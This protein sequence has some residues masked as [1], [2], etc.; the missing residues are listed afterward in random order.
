MVRILLECFNA[1]VILLMLDFFQTDIF[2]V[3]EGE[4]GTYSFQIECAVQSRSSVHRIYLQRIEERRELLCPGE[5]AVS[6]YTDD[7]T[8]QICI[9]AGVQMNPRTVLIVLFCILS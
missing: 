6:L 5:G 8:S 2:S 9:V 1:V 4:G 3:P 7:G